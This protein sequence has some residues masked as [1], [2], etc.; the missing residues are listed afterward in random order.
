MGSRGAPRSTRRARRAT[1]RPASTTPSGGSSSGP[2]VRQI[3]PSH[4]TSLMAAFL[5]AHGTVPRSLLHPGWRAALGEVAGLRRGRLVRGSEQLG[6]LPR[7]SVRD[8]GRAEHP[9]RH[10]DADPR[11]VS[12]AALCDRSY[13]ALVLTAPFTGSAPTSTTDRTARR[14]RHATRSTRPRPSLKFTTW[15]VSLC[16]LRRPTCACVGSDP[17]RSLSLQYESVLVGLL[18]IFSGKSPENSKCHGTTCLIGGKNISVHDWQGGEQS[19][20]RA[21]RSRSSCAA[22]PN[23]SD[24]AA[25]RR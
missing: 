23:V 5:P 25:A 1:A 2:S 21:Q 7:R 6:R 9:L 12:P 17:D 13:L 20:R 11:L 14:L 24:H 3:H 10:A 4:A 19:K 16:A 18:S 22:A 15:T 8:H